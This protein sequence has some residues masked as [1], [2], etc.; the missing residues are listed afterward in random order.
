MSKS[1]TAPSLKTARGLG[2]AKEGTDH[3]WMQ[4]LTGVALVPLSVWFVFAAAGLVGAD[5]TEFKAWVGRHGNPVMLI[6]LT[7]AMFHHTVLGMQV[8]IEDYVHSETAKVVSLTVVNLLAWLCGA[9]CIFAVLR[10]A[11]GG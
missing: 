5:L 2:S 4:R 7:V 11:F 1:Q 6:L 9:S 8:V 10:L 3:W